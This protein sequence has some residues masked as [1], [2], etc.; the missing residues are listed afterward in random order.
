MPTHDEMP[1]FSRAHRGLSAEQKSHFNTAVKK[2][3]SDLQDMESGVAKW[4]RD[5]LRVK[6]VNG[7]PG[8]WE[9]SWRSDGRATFRF[10][11]EQV[12]GKHHVVWDQIGG[13]EILP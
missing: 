7:P 10:G 4:F 12:P 1:G 6:K 11:E 2:F 13:H 5:S 3:V 8:L 9:M